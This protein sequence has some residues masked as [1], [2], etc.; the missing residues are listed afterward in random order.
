MSRESRRVGNRKKGFEPL[1]PLSTCY[2]RS[3]AGHGAH[4]QR[5]GSPQIVVQTE[6]EVRVPT[7]V[8]TPAAAFDPTA[9]KLSLPIR[10]SHHLGYIQQRLVGGNQDR[11]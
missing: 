6:L 11:T 1:G 2:K 5:A 7:F 9:H 8:E 4:S 10:Y 3:E